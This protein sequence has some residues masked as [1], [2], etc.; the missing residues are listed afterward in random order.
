MDFIRRKYM[1]HVLERNLDFLRAEVQQ[2]LSIFSPEHV[3]ALHYLVTSFPRAVVSKEALAQ[4]S[5]FVFLHMSQRPEVFDAVLRAAFDAPQLFVRALSRHFGAFAAAV[6]RYRDVCAA[7]LADPRFMEVAGRAAELEDVIGVNYDLDANPL[8]SGGEPVRDAELVFARM[9]RRTPFRAVK[10]LPALRLV[11]WAF[12]C[13]RDTGQTFADNDA[14]DLFTLLQRAGPVRHSELTERMRQ[15]MFPGDRPSYWVWLNAPVGS[16]ADVYRGR[17]ARS[18]HE[19]VLSYAYA[20]ARQG[21]VNANTLKLLYRLEGDPNV[22]RLL[23]QLIYDVPG[24]V[25]GVVDAANEEWRQYFAA[26]YREKFVDGRTFTSEA[27]FRDDLFRVVAA[28]DP[29]FFDPGRVR[30][31]FAADAATRERFDEMDLND[32]FMSHMVYGTEDPDARAAERGL[33]MRMYNEES[34]FFIREYNTYLFLNE[35][36][37]FV[38]ADGALQ[39]L[40]AVPPD[41]RAGL[42]SRSVLRYYVDAKL[43]SLGLVV[44]DYADVVAAMLRHLRRVEDVSGFVT[45]AARRTPAAVPGLVRAVLGHFNASVVAALRPFLRENM[46]RVEAFLDASAHLSAADKRYIRRAVLQGRA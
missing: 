26:L 33:A 39:R 24:D 42:F 35:E 37:P 29:D 23:L 40:S 18:L 14:Q 36:D 44:D 2:K 3:L 4:P 21:R 8:F 12:L 22:R 30:A 32:A 41:R 9:F 31:A 34:D 5:F 38:V 15:H 28:V 43:A 6:Q 19:R 46:T 17:E 7:L 25:V 45:Y 16:E 27:S 10:R 1:I 20:E 11:V 13:K